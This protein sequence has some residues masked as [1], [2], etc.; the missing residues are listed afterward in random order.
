M[1]QDSLYADVERLLGHGLRYK[2]VARL[3]GMP[4]PYTQRMASVSGVSC[5]K[6]GRDRRSVRELMR[7]PAEYSLCSAFL[8]VLFSI[9]RGRPLS[10]LSTRDVIA[11]ID[12]LHLTRPALVEECDWERAINSIFLL[13]DGLLRLV[14]CAQC[15][16]DVL[17]DAETLE[18]GALC[19]LCDASHQPELELA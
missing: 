15:R 4:L 13:D 14:P 9:L 2:Q 5:F 6:T 10:A 12:A 3:S 8:S 16:S 18:E 19:S 11:A 17:I 1:S 7:C